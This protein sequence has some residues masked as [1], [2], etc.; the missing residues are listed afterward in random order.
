MWPRLINVS[1]NEHMNIRVTWEAGGW[2]E[3]EGY[4][5]TSAAKMAG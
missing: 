3:L 5:Y 4:V 1:I 2:V